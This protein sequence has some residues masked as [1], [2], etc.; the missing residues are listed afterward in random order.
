MQAGSYVLYVHRTY[1]NLIGFIVLSR[2]SNRVLSKTFSE[3]EDADYFVQLMLDT[4]DRELKRE[5]V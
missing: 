2:C 4:T 1:F 5:Y 3:R